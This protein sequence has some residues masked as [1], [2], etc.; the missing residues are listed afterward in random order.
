MCGRDLL[1]SPGY[2]YITDL[3]YCVTRSIMMNFLYFY[4]AERRNAVLNGFSLQEGVVRREER[5]TRNEG[6]NLK[7]TINGG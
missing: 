7:I 5:D 6:R 3:D 2:S 1:T 4:H